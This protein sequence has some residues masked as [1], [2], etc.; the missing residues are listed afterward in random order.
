MR[1]LLVAA[2]LV[3]LTSCT[4][5]KK[6]STD[7]D[8]ASGQACA[9]GAC[10]AADGGTGGGSAG[11]GTGGGG[12]GGGA[13]G[14]S[15]GGGGS[16]GSGGGTVGGE[17]CAT[18][19]ALTLPVTDLLGTTSGAMDD[20]A[21]TGAAGCAD[22]ST[23]PDRVFAFDVPAGNRL[24]ASVLSVHWDAVLN[25]IAA[26]A[27][28]CSPADAGALSCLASADRVAGDATEVVSWLNTGTSPQTVFLL[29]D[30][31]AA[32][33]Q[34]DFLL[35]ASLAAPQPGDT[36]QLAGAPLTASTSLSQ[37]ALAGYL[38][39]YRWAGSPGCTASGTSGADRAYAVTVPAGQRVTATV[40]PASTWNAALNLVADCDALAQQC[41][42]G[43][44][45]GGSGVPETAGWTNGTGAARTV[46]VVVDSASPAP[47]TFDLA[48]T[49]GAPNA[50]DTCQLAERLDGGTVH[51]TTVGYDNDYS[52]TNQVGCVG[53]RGLDHVYAVTL[54]AGQRLIASAVTDGGDPSLSLIAGPSPSSCDANPRVC[55]ASRDTAGSVEGLTFLNRSG[56]DQSYF[57]V[58]DSFGAV[59]PGVA[60]DLTVSFDVPPAGDRC[61]APIALTPGTPAAGTTVGAVNDYTG[62]GA[63]CSSAAAQ[64]DVVYSVLV[65]A[66]QTLTATL[67]PAAGFDPSLSA[68]ADVAACDARS[69]LAGV[70]GAGPGG[71]EV[72]ALTNRSSSPQAML[73]VV[74]SNG[75]D[76]AFTLEASLATP[77]PGDFCG[78]ALPLGG[79]PVDGGVL[80][81]G[82][83]LAGFGDDYRGGTRC[84]PGAFEGVDRVYA[85]D[86]PAGQRLTLTAMPDAGLDL[87]LSLLA[88]VAAC[89]ASPRACV[90]GANLG[91]EGVTEQVRAANYGDAGLSLLAVVDSAAGVTA[92]AY[93]LQASWDTPPV[94]EEC[95]DTPAPLAMSG[96]V[97]GQTT[98]GYANDYTS[99][100]AVGCVGAASLDRVYEVVVPAGQRLNATA[101]ASGW[102]PSLSVVEG[103]AAAC[104]A[105]PR[106]CSASADLPGTTQTVSWANGA[107]ADRSVFLVV[108]SATGAGAFDL[109]VDFAAAQAGETCGGAQPITAGRVTNQSL[110]SFSRDLMLPLTGSTC[111]GYFGPE[112]VYSVS[113]PP[114]QRLTVEAQPASGDVVIDLIG[115]A[116]SAC[117]TG[118]AA[119]C[120][121]SADVGGSGVGETATW[122]NPGTSTVNVFVVV[123][124]YGATMPL[125]WS[126]NVTLQ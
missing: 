56:A 51:G 107:A 67:T 63:G 113:V 7:A 111:R 79:A 69:C 62:A 72:L 117:V 98:L 104:V 32:S 2:S 70:D 68:L 14:G 83:S 93:D 30:G 80:A 55:V 15:A 94:G 27:A 49:L 57:L 116:A 120:L 22:V 37:Q 112:R 33:D 86:V 123:G 31:Y 26:P 4:C 18:A 5:A 34:G 74:D 73:L 20:Y 106:F 1:R 110:A 6:C 58:V 10:V 19:Q 75:P 84:A 121:A 71:A 43:A 23:A 16:G 9:S 28:S 38:D 65:P 76:G 88:S 42:G 12:G 8:C 122:L 45:V 40:T 97:S 119:S 35:S 53:T 52:D 47:T 17:T 41:L 54:P 25:V 103:P 89:E 92:G 21:W 59:D 125:T 108:D 36:C 102:D 114:G 115:G 39:D 99:S 3:A 95:F 85:V 64:G 124:Q 81:A 87:S 78:T 105:S 29:V 91:A 118:S 100:D 101:T 60:Y 13:G 48:V 82:Q 46:Y 11:G 24:T 50:G 90:G 66:G 126:M 109:Q 44:D 77:P 96:V 61:E